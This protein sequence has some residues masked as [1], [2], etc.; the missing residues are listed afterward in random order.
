MTKLQ[1]VNKILN[2]ATLQE[3]GSN[4]LLDHFHF[5]VDSDNENFGDFRLFVDEKEIYFIEIY[6]EV[7]DVYEDE[8]NYGITNLNQEFRFNSIDGVETLESFVEE[9]CND[10]ET[11]KIFE[12]DGEVYAKQKIRYYHYTENEYNDPELSYNNEDV[13]FEFFYDGYSFFDWLYDNITPDYSVEQF[14]DNIFEITNKYTE[15]KEYFVLI[16]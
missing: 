11:K 14:E 12:V 15:E 8:I 10:P 2:G 9:L 4:N 6:G 7:T 13:Q 5:E 3:I 16:G 1:L